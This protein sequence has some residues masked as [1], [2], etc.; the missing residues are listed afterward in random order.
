MKKIKFARFGGL[1]SVNQRGYRSN[2]DSYHGPPAT[3]GFYAFVWPYYEFFLLSANCTSDPKTIGSKYSYVRDKDGNVIDDKHPEFEKLSDRYGCSNT[4]AYEK[5]SEENVELFDDNY[6]EYKKKY[7]EVFGDGGIARSVLVKRPGPR[8]FEYKGDIW[9]HLENTI[10]PHG[11]MK[12]KGG[13]IKSTF[14]EYAKALEKNMHISRRLQSEY[15]SNKGLPM[16]TKNPYRGICKDHL[17]VFIE[18]L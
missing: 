12:K 7:E 11:I 16:S 2:N 8:I 10:S 15:S 3:R 6:N 14:E 18:K 4:A 5:F 1:S 17:E 9:H 13:W